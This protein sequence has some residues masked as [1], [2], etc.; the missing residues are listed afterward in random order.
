MDDSHRD[1]WKANGYR[2]RNQSVAKELKAYADAGINKLINKLSVIVF[3]HIIKNNIEWKPTKFEPYSTAVTDNIIRLS[4]SAHLHSAFY[5]PYR[6]CYSAS[7]F[8]KIP[9]ADF[10]HFTRGHSY[11]Q[12]EL[13]ASVKIRKI[14]KI[15]I[16]PTAFTVANFLMK[17]ICGVSSERSTV[18]DC[19]C[20]S[21]ER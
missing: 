15:S 2:W 17:C 11:Q 6:T 19:T 10:P 14:N 9:V 13:L 21:V 16:S 20:I 8:N 1:D 3:K 12:L 18:S 7:S 5:P 4:H